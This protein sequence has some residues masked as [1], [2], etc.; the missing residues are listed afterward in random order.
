M[1]TLSILYFIQLVITR[2]RNATVSNQ[3]ATVWMIIGKR[4]VVQRNSNGSRRLIF[5]NVI[6]RVMTAKNGADFVHFV[7]PAQ[8]P[9]SQNGQ[10]RAKDYAS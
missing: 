1:M 10:S 6:T 7:T 9:A 4:R 8:A 2:S 3:R 5:F